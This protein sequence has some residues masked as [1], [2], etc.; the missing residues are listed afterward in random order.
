MKMKH[1]N[2]PSVRDAI[3][4]NKVDQIKAFSILRRE[5]IHRYNLKQMKMKK[6]VLQAKC[7]LQNIDELVV[8]HFC[9][10]FVSKNGLSR[11]LGNCSTAP[12][13]VNKG[14]KTTSV[15]NSGGNFGSIPR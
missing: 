13:H 1:K 11:H 14:N 10:G 4:M 5:G 9:N 8:C 12:D 3:Q 7:G 2:E 6:P 15:D